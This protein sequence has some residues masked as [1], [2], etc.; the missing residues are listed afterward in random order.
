LRRFKTKAGIELAGDLMRAETILSVLEPGETLGV[1]AN[2]GWS[3]VVA[4]AAIAPLEQLG[5]SFIE[6]PVSPALPDVMASLTASTAVPIVA[7]ESIFTIRDGFDAANRRLAD[8]WALTPS[9]HG[10][11]C[12]TLDLLAIAGAAGIPCLLGS[13]IELGVSTAMMTQIGCAFDSIRECP[14]AS[15]VIGPLYHE[16]DIVVTQPRIEGG[17]AMVPAGPGLGVELDWEKVEFYRA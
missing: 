7:H 6:Q 9:T 5:V 14:V 10:G 15:D 4:R 11:I 13:N 8:V 16:G 1:D 3:P 12:P 17:M 2:A